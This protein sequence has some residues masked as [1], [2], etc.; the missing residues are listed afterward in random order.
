MNRIKI[1]I[2]ALAVA[3]CGFLTTP[4]F[5]ASSATSVDCPADLPNRDL[6]CGSTTSGQNEQSLM[7][8]V[9]NVLN[10]IYGMIGIVAVVMIVVGGFKY[11]TSQGDPGKIQSA[12]N[13]IMYSV[14]GLV[15]TLS[16]FAITNFILGALK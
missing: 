10:V 8:T 1:C 6:I 12:K 11:M 13:T 2:F 15:I 9:G 14:I 7:S 16:A 5:A 3:I 4:T